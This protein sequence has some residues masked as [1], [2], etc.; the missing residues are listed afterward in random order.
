MDTTIT[1]VFAKE[2]ISIQII[3]EGKVITSI[4]IDSI[5]IGDSV[6]LD[7][8]PAAGYKFVE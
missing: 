6:T 7:A 8:I 4:H 3:G 5:Q 1:A 2:L